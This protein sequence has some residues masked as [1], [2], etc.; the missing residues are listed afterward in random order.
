MVPLQ[1]V[2]AGT[3][4]LSRQMAPVDALPYRQAVVR[5]IGLQEL[6][7]TRPVVTI[8]NKQARLGRGWLRG[9]SCLRARVC[10]ASAPHAS[11]LSLGS[12][13]ARRVRCSPWL[14]RS[15]HSSP[16]LP[17]CPLQGRRMIENSREVRAY[18]AARYPLAQV[19]MFDFGEHPDMTMPQQ[20]R[21]DAG[22]GP[23]GGVAVVLWCMA[24]PARRRCSLWPALPQPLPR[25]PPASAWRQPRPACLRAPGCRSSSCPT[26]PS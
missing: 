20:A 16:A 1:A 22:A 7:Q 4:Y 25:H 5:H 12:E 21:A 11:H 14:W 23:R 15:L 24:A 17:C 10:A 9:T 2:L 19:D 13:G 3:G 6:P 8:L 26:R 18:L